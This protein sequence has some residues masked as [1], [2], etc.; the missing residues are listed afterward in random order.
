MKD[1]EIIKDGITDTSE[2]P[3][4]KDIFYRCT[5]CGGV[6]P[7]DPRENAG[8]SCGNI[9]IDIDYFRLAVR[10]YTKFQA[11]RKRQ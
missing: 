3:R 11:I 4:G 10:D 7:S 5:K 9:F 2:A 1:Y 6:I 8:C